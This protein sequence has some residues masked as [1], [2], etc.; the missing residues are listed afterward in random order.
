MPKYEVSRSRHGRADA[1]DT[2]PVTGGGHGHAAWHHLPSQSHSVVDRR[3]SP[4]RALH[5]QLQHVQLLAGCR[6]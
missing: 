5:I 3:Q 4:L 1:D 2:P 6:W